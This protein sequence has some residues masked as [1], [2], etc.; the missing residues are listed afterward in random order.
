M[1]PLEV[2]VGDSLEILPNLPGESIQCCITSP[3]YWGLRDYEHAAQIGSEPSPVDYVE[4]LVK[5][6][7]EVKRILREDGTLWLNIGDGY[8]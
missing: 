1:N 2:L 8:A 5:M 6:F 3:P 4:N 7:R